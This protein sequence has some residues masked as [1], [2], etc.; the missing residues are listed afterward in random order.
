MLSTADL[1]AMRATLDAS[2]PDSC[3]VVRR[4]TVPDGAGGTTDTW[5]NQGG[6]VACRLSPVSRSDRL[7]EREVAGELVAVTYWTLT[8]PDAT[9]VTE[10]DRV[11]VAGRTFEV[12]SV[13]TRSWE[14][15][16]RVLVVEVE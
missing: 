15:S 10:R 3:Q 1:D 16:R 11:T 12:T 9:D 14:I 5:A 2:L 4:S 6:A 13:G 7:A 8:F